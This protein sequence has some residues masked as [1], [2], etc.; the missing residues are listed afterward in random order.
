MLVYK[1]PNET[2]IHT[3]LREQLFMNCFIF[4][5]VQIITTHLKYITT[6]MVFTDITGL[7]I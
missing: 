1:V 7:C 5:E 3:V 4:N 6:L 2:D